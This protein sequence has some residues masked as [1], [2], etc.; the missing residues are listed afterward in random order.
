[1]LLLLLVAALLV[2]FISFLSN[3]YIRLINLRRSRIDRCL[4]C[5]RSGSCAFSDFCNDFVLLIALTF[6]ADYDDSRRNDLYSDDCCI[7]S[8]EFSLCGDCY[9]L[10]TSC[11]FGGMSWQRCKRNWHFYA[12][13]SRRSLKIELQAQNSTWQALYILIKFLNKC[14]QCRYSPVRLPEWSEFR[15]FSGKISAGIPLDSRNFDGM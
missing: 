13:K 7:C 6:V 14:I 2:R 11:I 4:N 9:S 3:S 10:Y 1:M 5:S 8:T 12:E 15:R